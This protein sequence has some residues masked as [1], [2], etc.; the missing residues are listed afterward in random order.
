MLFSF[1]C[2]CE[3]LSKCR[4]DGRVVS[5]D[6]LACIAKEVGSHGPLVSQDK[7]H[8]FPYLWERQACLPVSPSDCGR[9][10]LDRTHN[11]TNPSQLTLSIWTSLENESALCIKVVVQYVGATRYGHSLPLRYTTH[12]VQPMPSTPPMITAAHSH[13]SYTR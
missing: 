8:A 7:H 13:E 9:H 4:Y 5:I 11:R 6:F 12:P 2:V 1:S 10:A 3:K